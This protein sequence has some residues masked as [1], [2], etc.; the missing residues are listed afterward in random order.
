[1][2]DCQISVLA[3][4][5]LHNWQTANFFAAAAEEEVPFGRRL[6]AT[7]RSALTGLN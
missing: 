2:K 7:S 6:L 4:L 5:L 3:V 1:M